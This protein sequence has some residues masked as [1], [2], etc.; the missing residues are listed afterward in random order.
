MADDGIAKHVASATTAAAAAAASV[1]ETVLEVPVRSNATFT[2]HP[3]YP[4]GVEISGY[5]GNDW[6]LPQ[7]LAAFTIGC[8]F[9]FGVAAAAAM[10]RRPEISKTDL[11]TVLWFVLCGCLHIFFEGFF[12]TNF[13]T[14]GGSKHVFG[15]LWKEYSLSD[16]RYLTQNTFV[17]C[18]ESITV[19][20]WGP[21]SIATA[22]FVAT[23][24]PLRHP[25]QVIVSLG[26]LYGDVLYY[27]TTVVDHALLGVS[28]SRPE[29]YYFWLY[30][31]FMNAFWIVIPGVL[32]YN[33]VKACARAFRALAKMERSL[34]AV[35]EVTKA[36]EL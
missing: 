26:H 4:P 1:S 30:F 7:L 21:L 16:S 28:Y 23:E 31:V 10:K 32:I 17:L 20:I 2:P 14:I 27:G 12:V 24:H 34:R 6:T 3:Y 33:S 22:Y 9:I 18:I 25:F 11:V 19:V 13:E 35:S 5:E 15:Q 29:P 8:V 36:K